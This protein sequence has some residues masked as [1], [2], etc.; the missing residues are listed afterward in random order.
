M[1]ILRLVAWVLFCSAIAVGSAAGYHLVTTTDED[2][3]GGFADGKVRLELVPGP[4]GLITMLT[5]VFPDDHTLS[6]LR[7]QL[8]TFAAFVE[9]DSFAAWLMVCPAQH[10]PA[11]RAFLDGGLPDLPP[12]LDDIVRVVADEAC[13]PELEPRRFAALAFNDAEFVSGWLKQQLLKLACAHLVT[14]PYYL[15]TDADTFFLNPFSAGDLFHKQECE[16]RSYTVCDKEHKISYRALSEMHDYVNGTQPHGKA[17]WVHNSAATLQ[18]PSPGPAVTRS[19]GV[20]PQI[21]SRSLVAALAAHLDRL[22]AAEVWERVTWR[23]YLVSRLTDYFSLPKGEQL[24]G[25]TPWTEYNLYWVFAV[26]AGLWDRYHVHGQLQSVGANAWH[27][28][29]FD[30]WDPCANS[31]VDAW[32]PGLWGTVQS[33]VK[34]KGRPVSGEAIWK[35]LNPCVPDWRQRSSDLI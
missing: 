21:L 33:V 29:E 20:T 1:G 19:I 3:V 30:L 25:N 14:T 32:N 2:S 5:P 4:K 15:I 10:L 12:A 28:T 31:V 34:V 8:R 9:V 13:A 16:G 6:L 24:R 23:A 17:L 18:L 35:K 7:N 27:S 26:H 22:L 11:L